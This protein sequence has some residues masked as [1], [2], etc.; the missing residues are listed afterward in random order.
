LV[1]DREADV[2]ERA[3]A[4]ASGHDDLDGEGHSRALLVSQPG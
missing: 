3:A 1:A 4:E 2:M